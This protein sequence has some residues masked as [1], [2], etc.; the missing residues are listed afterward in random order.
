MGPCW[1]NISVKIRLVVRIGNEQV[2]T[3]V[4]IEISN[5]DAASIL[6]RIQSVPRGFVAEDMTVFVMEQALLL[7]AA[8]GLVSDRR[9]VAG[10]GKIYVGPGDHLEDIGNVTFFAS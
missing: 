10:I 3:P 1:Q 5:R 9:P 2:E 4:V 8:Q 7:V 6:D